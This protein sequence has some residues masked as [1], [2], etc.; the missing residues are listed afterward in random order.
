MFQSLKSSLAGYDDD[1]NVFLYLLGTDTYI[2]TSFNYYRM[3]YF[4]WL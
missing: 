3:T 1:F 4:L 2:H